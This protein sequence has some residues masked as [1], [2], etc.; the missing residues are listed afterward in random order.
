MSDE[1]LIDRMC[2]QIAKMVF[3]EIRRDNPGPATRVTKAKPADH[4]LGARII[5]RRDEI[6]AENAK[7]RT[8]K[9][10]KPL[11]PNAANKIRKYL[12]ENGGRSNAP[13]TLPKLSFLKDMADKNADEI[14]KANASPTL[15]PNHYEQMQARYALHN[16]IQIELAK[17]KS[18]KVEHASPPGGSDS[19]DDE[20]LDKKI[21][22]IMK[23]RG[24]GVDKF[25]LAAS[26]ALKGQGQHRRDNDHDRF[27]TQSETGLNDEP[28]RS[29]TGDNINPK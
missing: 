22:R 2:D 28:R 24:W 26:E 13:V 10:E 11:S 29:V 15:S 6:L 25:D 16:Q 23:E 4:D 7:Q 3:T 21:A 1:A 8:A 5:A 27:A 20:P 19:D 17:S 12:A 18:P 14:A 9:M